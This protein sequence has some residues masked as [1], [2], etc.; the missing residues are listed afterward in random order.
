M[1]EQILYYAHYAL[2]LIFGI[3][4]SA[5]FAGVTA[6]GKNG[7]RLLLLAALCGGLQ[8]GVYG[9]FGENAVWQWYPLITHL[10]MVLALR[11]WFGRQ[12]SNAVSATATAYLCCQIAKWFGLAARTLSGDVRMELAVRIIVL[13]VTLAVLLRWISEKIAKLFNPAH[14]SSWI[15]G[16]TPVVYYLFDYAVAIYSSLWSENHQLVVEFLPLFLCIGYLVFCAVYYREYELKN[17]AER[18][19]QIL[20]IT[21]DQQSKE[22]EMIRRSEE[23]IRRLR[24]DLKLFLNS[25]STCIEQADKETARKLISGF[26]QQAEASSVIRYC[27]ND[28]LNY[29]L[30]DYAARCQEKG[31]RFQPTIEL[32]E[33]TADA[34]LFSTIL[35]NALDN[36]LNAQ[37]RQN[38]NEGEQRGDIRLL[39]KNNC[40]KTLLCVKN[41]FHEAPLFCNGIPA[42]FREGHGYG[43][44]SIL[45]ITEK[46][47]GNCQFTI[48]EN[49]F[50]LRVVV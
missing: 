24:H 21:V 31:I 42:S 11:F 43:V 49:L 20:R 39:L 25:L 45:Y 5:A 50:V 30:S 19:E 16:I 33:L 36:A 9:L 46:L 32:A 6:T 22:V 12:L 41:T 38:A 4:V 18:K 35:A 2:L 48:E 44:Q 37:Y 7:G 15:F 17:E 34:L 47:G 14:K 28:T 3:V 8:I 1:M 23:E 13:L 27:G 29:V 26:S 10:P 40:G